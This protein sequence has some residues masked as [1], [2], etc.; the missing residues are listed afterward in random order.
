MG[1][2][3]GKAVWLTGAL[4]LV[5]TAFCTA[6]AQAQR[7]PLITFYTGA[8]EDGASWRS[9]GSVSNTT[10]YESI[11]PIRSIVVTSGTWRLCKEVNFTGYCV[12]LGPGPHRVGA[13]DTER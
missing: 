7:V 9:N 12:T 10:G 2:F 5:V 8:N 6:P 13:A 4:A 11:G 1:S 3:L